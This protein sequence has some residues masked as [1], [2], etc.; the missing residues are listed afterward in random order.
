M[1]KRLKR[2][3]PLAERTASFPA[4]VY[5]GV[6]AYVRDGMSLFPWFSV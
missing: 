5:D 4:L 3:I 2:W 6:D 1:F